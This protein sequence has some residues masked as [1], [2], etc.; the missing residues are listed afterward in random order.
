MEHS[1]AQHDAL[2]RA[3]ALAGIDRLRSGGSN[4]AAWSRTSWICCNRC[5]MK[6]G[7]WTPG[8]WNARRTRARCWMRIAK[9]SP[10]KCEPGAPRSRARCG[11]RCDVAM[12]ARR[13]CRLKRWT[14]RAIQ[15]PSW[16]SGERRHRARDGALSRSVEE[17]VIG[18]MIR[19]RIGLEVYGTNTELEKVSTGSCAAGGRMQIEFGFAAIYA[20]ANTPSR[21]RRTMPTA[22]RTIGWTM[23]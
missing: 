2:V 1:L 9:A 5:A 17:P 3:R 8:R 16:R 19:T 7:G 20:P 14:P 4:G 13:F 21:P 11:P 12:A 22:R 23:Q 15:P 18:I 10:K 6:S